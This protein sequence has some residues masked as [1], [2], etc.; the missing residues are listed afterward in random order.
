MKNIILIL[1][2]IVAGCTTVTCEC[3]HTA[4]AQYLACKES[5]DEAEIV[6]VDDNLNDKSNHAQARARN[7]GEPWTYFDNAWMTFEGSKKPRKGHKVI[8]AYKDI[9][10]F[11]NDTRKKK[12]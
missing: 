9:N 4:V 7:K 12:K 3:R 2:I 5:F 8:K 6:I 10:Q 11:I 1:C